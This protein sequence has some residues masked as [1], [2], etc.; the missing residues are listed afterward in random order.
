MNYHQP[1]LLEEVLALTDPKPGKIIIDATLGN[2]GHSQELLKRGAI[3]FGIETDPNNLAL[4][5][6]RLQNYINF[7]PIHDNFTNLE[8]IAKDKIQS[9]VDAIIID[10]GLSQ[11]QITG[12]GRGFSF[13]D[14]LS[15]DMR[16]DASQ[17]ELTAEAIINTYSYQQL[18]DIFTR[19]SQE[20]Y[21]KPI[22]LR[23]ISARQK[24]PIKK[25]TDLAT[26]IRSYYHEKMIRYNID[27]ATKIFLA[28]KIEVNDEFN[29]LKSVLPQTSKILKTGG[30]CA[31]ISF[32]SGEDRIV[33]LFIKASQFTSSGRITPLQTEALS[34]KLSRSATLRWFRI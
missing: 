28:L 20:L 34:N 29:N 14:D 9:Q 7:H 4:A 27:P 2:G 6:D 18:V 15:L 19:N 23:I 10:L 31:I 5:S 8:R 16:L 33:K 32:H 24:K 30:V 13:N 12:T 3:V 25:A 17:Q 22:A 11:N 26:I 21:A 1:V